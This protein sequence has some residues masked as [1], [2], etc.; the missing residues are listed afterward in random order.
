MYERGR[1]QGLGRLGRYLDS[2]DGAAGQRPAQTQVDASAAGRILPI[3]GAAAIDHPL[4]TRAGSFS[5]LKAGI[6]PEA[7]G[8]L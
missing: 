8:I 4:E 7:G 6:L 5:R 2:L 1:A 3:D